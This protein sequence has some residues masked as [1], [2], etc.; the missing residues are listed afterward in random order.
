MVDGP[1]REVRF[2]V[3]VSTF[4]RVAVFFWF[5]DWSMRRLA[6]G[7]RTPYKPSSSSDSNA[8]F[9]S[10]GDDGWRV[11]LKRSP[12][13]F[14]SSVH[15]PSRSRWILSCLCLLL[16]RRGSAAA[17]VVSRHH[18]QLQQEVSQ[19]L[20]TSR[21][22]TVSTRERWQKTQ[23]EE[24]SSS[25]NWRF[26]YDEREAKTKQAKYSIKGKRR[27]HEIQVVDKNEELSCSIVCIDV[28]GGGGVITVMNRCRY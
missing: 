19:L 3:Q 2:Y 7:S 10:Y 4:R 17:V 22:V 12:S 26:I 11:F 21:V 27:W 6:L 1:G 24:E 9:W 16:K 5:V 28:V 25:S 18:T 20:L 15:R 23:A 13:F 14:F 8:A